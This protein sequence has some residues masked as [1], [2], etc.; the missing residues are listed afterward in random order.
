[1]R[2]LFVTAVV[3]GSVPLILWRPWIGILMWAWISYMNPH[4]L[5]WGFA[6]SMPFAM[7]IA[8]ATLTGLL[9]S[10]E[11]KKVPMT[12]ET[13]ILLALAGWMVVTTTFAY[14]Q[15]AWMQL[16]KVAKILLMTFVTMM[17][18]NTK[19]RLHAFVWAIALSI[20]FFGVKGGIFTLLTGGSHRVYGPETTFIAG[21]NE[22]ALALLMVIPLMRYLQ[23]NS[24]QF[25]IR[26][27][28]GAAMFLSAIAAIGSQSRGALLAISAT[29]LFFWAKSRGKVA[30]A[31][32][33]VLTIGVIVPLMPQSWYDRMATIENYE[34]DGSAL[35]RINAW[36]FAF[37]LAKARPLVGGGFE[38][39]QPE[40]FALYAPEPWRYHDVHSIYFEMLGEHGFV[41]LTLFLLLALFAWLTASQVTRQCRHRADLKPI[42]DLVR[43][44]Q[45]SLVAYATG[46]AF[47]G[48][49]YFDLFYHLVAIVVIAAVV[50]R[51]ALQKAPLSV[52]AAV[53][54]QAPPFGLPNT[55]ASVNK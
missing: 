34:Q 35:G 4:K 1:M 19:Q 52:R 43:M 6:Y 47:L 40:L 16:D 53:S 45:A 30:T 11:P 27:G 14:Y 7:I 31:L 2:D 8:L 50:A 17:L 5:A 28:L 26:A 3:F 32:F 15:F 51:N 9:F 20:G 39:F 29:A 41:G 49:A 46:G 36:W 33:I 54:A 38:T 44:V 55:A 24:G 18:I 13:G 48:L 37:N 21:N 12:R 42:A 23:L 22:I 25:V 10:K